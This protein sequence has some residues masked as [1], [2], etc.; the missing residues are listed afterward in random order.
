MEQALEND[1]NK[2][3]SPN[4]NK[5]V[6]EYLYSDT[7]SSSMTN[8]PKRDRDGNGIYGGSGQG[9]P[10]VVRSAKLTKVLRDVLDMTEDDDF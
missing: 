10:V 7:T 2:C 6:S 3:N 9:S 1:A 5:P 8:R 4:S